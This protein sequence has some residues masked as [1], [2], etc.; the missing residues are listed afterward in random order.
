MSDDEPK[1]AELSTKNSR[2]S[3]EGMHIRSLAK[4]LEVLGMFTIERAEWT[5]K[6]I[7]RETGFPRPTAYRL[8]RTLEDEHYLVF[9]QQTSRYHL[10][11]AMIPALYLLQCHRD[12]VR[13]LHDHLQELA[14][15]AGEHASLAVEVD[16][17]AVVIDSASSSHNLF[18]PNIPI[19]RVHEGLCT[20]HLKL[21]AA[22]KDQD[23]L[24]ALLAQP[25]VAHTV[26]TIIDPGML[27][28][29]MAMVVHE[30]VA[31]DIEE[32]WMRVC[33]VA[34]PVRDRSGAVAASVSV[35]VSVERFGEERRRLLA[36]TV[37]SFAAKM[38]AKL[39]YSAE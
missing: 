37:R 23:E 34:A 17:T 16:R 1:K 18:Q 25:Q 11:P 29:Q 21:L 24:A 31:Y 7:V 20:A 35:V 4:G 6:D 22:F 13:L 32:R 15:N 5:L 9:N 12:L 30:G 3:G 8:V 2:E 39:G 19:G 14:E 26:H 36:E 10:G 33:A 27:A 28:A 38:S